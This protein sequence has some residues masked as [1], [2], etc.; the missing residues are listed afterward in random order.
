M[1]LIRPDYRESAFKEI[2]IIVQLAAA[3]ALR[4]R[5]N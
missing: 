4:V 1:G 5:K 3:I 2:E